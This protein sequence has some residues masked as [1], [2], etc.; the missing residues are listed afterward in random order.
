VEVTDVT[1]APAYN[2][3]ELLRVQKGFWVQA[4]TYFELKDCEKKIAAGTIKLFTS[5][6]HVLA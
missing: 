1:N 3:S 4:P 2:I 6:I 5:V